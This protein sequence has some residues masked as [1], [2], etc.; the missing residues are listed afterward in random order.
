MGSYQQLR[1]GGR[2][3][4]IV[5]TIIE[6][7]RQCNLDRDVDLPEQDAAELDLDQRDAVVGAVY[8]QLMEIESRLLPCGLHTIGKPPT[9]EEAIATLVSIAA[10]EREDDGL[11]SLPGL[12]AEAIDRKIE[13]IYK[14]N[15]DGILADVEL[16]RTITE[17]SRVAVRAM[18][19]SLTGRDGRVNMKDNSNWYLDWFFNPVSYTHLTLPTKRIV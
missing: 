11:R 13:D 10:L 2:G 9:A 7:A 19:Q 6:T 8:S 12:L 18:V 3:V 15:D 1:E 4:Q 16:N 5:N 17:A 14:G